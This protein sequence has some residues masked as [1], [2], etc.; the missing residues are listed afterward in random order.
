MRVFEKQILEMRN[1]KEVSMYSGLPFHSEPKKDY[2]YYFG[3]MEFHKNFMERSGD[4]RD[5]KN[6]H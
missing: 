6:N 3:F 4:A 1:R 2:S 5:C